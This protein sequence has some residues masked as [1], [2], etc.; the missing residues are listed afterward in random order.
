MDYFNLY[1]LSGDCAR[2]RYI[3]FH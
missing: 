2:D 3:R 1:F